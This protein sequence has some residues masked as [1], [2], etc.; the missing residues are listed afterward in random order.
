VEH[1][2]MHN[3]ATADRKRLLIVLAVTALY[4]AAEFIG[5]YYA[6]SLALISDAVHM[7]TD[8]AALCLRVRL[9]G[10]RRV[11]VRVLHLPRVDHAQANNRPSRSQPEIAREFPVET[12]RTGHWPHRSSRN[13]EARQDRDRPTRYP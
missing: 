2:E 11:S 1:L 4:C 10:C 9:R 3:A 6:N 7:L 8:I 5:G 12:R 13:A